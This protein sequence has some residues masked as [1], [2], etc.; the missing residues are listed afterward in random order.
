MRALTPAT[1]HLRLQASPPTAIYLP[2]VPPQP[3]DV[4]AHHFKRQDSVYGDFQASPFDILTMKGRVCSFGKIVKKNEAKGG[5]I[6]KRPSIQ[7][8]K[9]GLT[10]HEPMDLYFALELNNTK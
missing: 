9:I 1:P 4:S 10:L 5:D 6:K 2:V 8:K 7:S 3:P